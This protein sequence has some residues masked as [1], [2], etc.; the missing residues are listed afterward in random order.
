LDRSSRNITTKAHG[1]KKRSPWLPAALPLQLLFGLLIC[2]SIALAQ[3]PAVER[4]WSLLAQGRRDEAVSL[5]YSIIKADPSDADA[6]LLLGSVL[7]EEGQRSESIAQLSDAVRLRPQSAQAQDALGEA[8]NAFGE[9][10]QARGAFE[11]A[12]MLNPGFAQAQV[13]LGLV[14]LKSGQPFA[15]QPHLDRAIQLLGESSDAA[16][17]YY[18]RAKIYTER[19]QAR[20]A[21]ADLE[22]AVSLDPKFAEAWSDLGEAR[23]TL[24]DQ[25]GALEAFKKAVSFA[26]NDPVAQ[27]RLGSELLEQGKAAEAVPHLQE[28][29]HL[30]PENQSALYN[31]ERA[32]GQDGHPAQAN[33]VK[34]ELLALLHSRDRRDQSVFTATE[35]NDQGSALEKAGNLQAA[36]EKYRAALQLNP[37]YVGIRVN[38]AAALLHLG[39]WSEGVAELREVLRVDPGNYAVKKALQEALAHPSQAAR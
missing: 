13:D 32:L 16:F 8:F 12:S 18:L 36:L 24:L 14:L 23:T 35:L 17:P 30:D 9:I 28:A 2:A 20:K 38:Y 25:A 22:E 26:P 3:R 33:A 27:T 39:R 7:M 31:L 11:K 15:A 21:A 1:E 34:E 19:G 4:A 37:G 5:L 29:A 10:N 6:R